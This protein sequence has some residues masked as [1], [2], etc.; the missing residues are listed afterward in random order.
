MDLMD[1]IVDFYKDAPRLGPGSAD[2]TLKAL[3]LIPNSGKFKKILDIGSGTGAQT[4]ILAEKTK[5]EIIAIDFIIEFIEILQE[6]IA[7]KKIKYRV[8]AE[9]MD[10][11]EMP[12]R[13]EEFDLIWSEGAIYN[14]GFQVGIKEWHKLIKRG[15]YLAVTEMTWLSP[16]RP[17]AIDT[18]WKTAYADIDTKENKI[19]QLQEA[20]YE[21]VDS[22]ILP[23]SCWNDEYYAPLQDLFEPFLAKYPENADAIEFIN[24]I[25]EEIKLYNEFKEYYGY[26]FYIAKKK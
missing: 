13:A 3:D 22:F 11:T 5:A 15:G 24:G 19:E 4:M 12:F 1:L 25:K 16:Q 8:S 6:K 10:M 21:I 9:E 18:Y 23:E 7:K 17:D 26:V 20:G 2:T 14:V